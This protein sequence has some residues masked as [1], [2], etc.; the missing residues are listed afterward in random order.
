VLQNCYAHLH[1]T[2]IASD[3]CN[4]S[5]LAAR[6]QLDL[7]YVRIPIRDQ[8]ILSPTTLQT[9]LDTVV[10]PEASESVILTL[11]YLSPSSDILTERYRSVS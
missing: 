6:Q 2:G 8:H 3:V 4:N 7:T 1:Y 9:I 11:L 5:E 10:F